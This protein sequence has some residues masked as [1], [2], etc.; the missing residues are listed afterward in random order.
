LGVETTGDARVRKERL[1]FR[2]KY[3]SLAIVIIEERTYAHAIT[4]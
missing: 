4:A 1:D 2:A 3:E